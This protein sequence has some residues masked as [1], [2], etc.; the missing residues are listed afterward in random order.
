MEDFSRFLSAIESIAPELSKSPQFPRKLAEYRQAHAVQRVLAGE[1]L[2][3]VAPES[4]KSMVALRRLVEAVQRDGL[5]AI[6]PKMAERAAKISERRNGIAQI[7][8]GRLAERR[9]ELLIPSIGAGRDISIEP[10]LE[11]RSTTDYLIKNGGGRGVCRLNIKFHGTVF[12]DAM[13]NVGLEPEDCFALATY[14][15]Y[16]A[17]Q[18]QREDGFPYVFLVLSNPSL[19]AASVAG[20]V[21]L[22]FAWLLTMLDGKRFVEEAIA[23]YLCRPEFQNQFEGLLTRMAEGEFRAISAAKADDLLHKLLFDR[24]F[25]I[26]VPRFVQVTQVNMHFSLSQDL[27][28]FSRFMELLDLPLHVLTVRLYEGEAI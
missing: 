14:K 6:I 13:E 22:E 19:R 25:A 2:K 16:S 27:A 24:V 4:G 20:H 11:D 10:R 1:D 26:R 9:F 15:I 28:P 7:L 5:A 21:P 17:L 3:L 12:R 23:D 8:L 18:R